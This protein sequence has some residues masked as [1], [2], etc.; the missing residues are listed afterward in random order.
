MLQ[1]DEKFENLREDLQLTEACD[2]AGFIRNV[3]PGQFFVTIHDIH[4]NDDRSEP[5]V[6]IRGNTKFGQVMEVKIT[7]HFDRQGI[8]IKI[9]SMQKR[10]SSILDSHQQEY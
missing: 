6:L 5:E 7:K 1:C 10:R 4:R 8:D 2:D 3:S 9:D